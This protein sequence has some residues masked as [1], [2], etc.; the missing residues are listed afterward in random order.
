MQS[1]DS[2]FVA[3]N[4]SKL[5][6]GVDPDGVRIT[7]GALTQIA[8]TYMQ[9]LWKPFILLRAAWTSRLVGEEQAR[10]WAADMTSVFNHPISHIAWVL[11]TPSSGKYVGK[12]E[13]ALAKIPG[14]KARGVEDIL[15][16][17]SIIGS[18]LDFILLCFTLSDLIWTLFCLIMAR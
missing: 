6:Y 11:G 7:E 18:Y 8:D 15:G 4:I 9:A 17:P 1:E 12:V 16:N 13:N 3:K 5:F 14:V 2:N 10:M